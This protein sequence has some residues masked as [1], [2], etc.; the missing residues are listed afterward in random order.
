LLLFPDV[1]AEEF[2]GGGSCI[3]GGSTTTVEP[4]PDRDLTVIADASSSSV[5][6]MSEDAC[7]IE[8]DIGSG[9]A[10]GDLQS[11]DG[12]LS[13]LT[14]LVGVTNCTSCLGRLFSCLSLSHRCSPPY[15]SEALSAKLGDLPL[16]F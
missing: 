12:R 7:S 14:P 5:L 11:K 2:S 6:K 1:S 3:A 15:S 10:K 13:S 9:D 16:S 4:V 8:I